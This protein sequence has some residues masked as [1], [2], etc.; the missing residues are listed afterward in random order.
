MW[1]YDIYFSQNMFLLVLLKLP[2]NHVKE[3]NQ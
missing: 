1:D 3:C 2:E